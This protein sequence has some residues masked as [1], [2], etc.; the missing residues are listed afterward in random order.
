GHTFYAEY[1]GTPRSVSFWVQ[2]SD[3]N[4]LKKHTAY[5]YKMFLNTDITSGVLPSRE[6][7]LFVDLTQHIWTEH[8]YIEVPESQSLW[9]ATKSDA[10][11]DDFYRFESRSAVDLNHPSINTH[12]IADESFHIGSLEIKTGSG[13]LSNS[14]SS[15][16]K[17][18]IAFFKPEAMLQFEVYREADHVRTKI[19]ITN[20]EFYRSRYVSQGTIRCDTYVLSHEGMIPD[21]DTVFIGMRFAEEFVPDD[22]VS[23][24]VYEGDYGS[25][26]EALKAGARD[27]TQEIWMSG[28]NGIAD[29]GGNPVLMFHASILTLP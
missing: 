12:S 18:D 13:N 10:E 28:A 17:I 27:I 2:G 9:I 4:Y 6:L 24:A 5:Y 15:N 21:D 16:Y 19:P 3:G 20:T 23:V 7:N 8:V 11:E 25:L 14:N 1:S 29:G 22:F 26:D